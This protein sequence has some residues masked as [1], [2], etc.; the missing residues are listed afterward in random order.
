MKIHRGSL[1]AERCVFCHYPHTETTEGTANFLIKVERIQFPE[2][3]TSGSKIGH[4]LT[5]SEGGGGENAWRFTSTTHIR[6]HFSCGAQGH[7]SDSLFPFIERITRTGSCTD[8]AWPSQ[9]I[10]YSTSR[11]K[12]VPDILILWSRVLFKSWRSISWSRNS[13][14]FMELCKFI[15]VFTRAR[16]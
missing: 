14:S 15:T 6:L 2:A 10:S 16:N 12:G 3:E 4:L 1:R 11:K 13:P 8:Q 7:R 9:E 5:A